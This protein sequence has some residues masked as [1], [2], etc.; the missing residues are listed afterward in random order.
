[1]YYRV[2][3]EVSSI[4]IRL[5]LSYLSYITSPKDSKLAIHRK[6]DNLDQKMILI[7]LLARMEKLSIN[8]K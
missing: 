4:G 7:I 8:F 6:G 3:G 5:E 1:M 2:F